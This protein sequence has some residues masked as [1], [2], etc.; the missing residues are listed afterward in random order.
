MM[1]RSF[2]LTLAAGLL[3]SL[4]FTAPCQAGGTLVTTNIEFVAFS[5]AVTTITLDY[6][7][8]AGSI[9]DLGGLAFSGSPNPTLASTTNTVTLTF[10]PATS[11]FSLLKFTFVDTVVAFAN[12]PADITLTSVTGQ[13]GSQPVSTTTQA[14]LSYAPAAAVPEPTSMALLGI[15]MTGFLAFRRLFKRTSVA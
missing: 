13:P 10:T 8:G 2:F 11:G 1:K 14:I 15:G 7:L 5:P 3:A 6:S 9:S 12:A 4:A